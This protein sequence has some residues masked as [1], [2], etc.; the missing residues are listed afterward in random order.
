MT[1]EGNVIY[2]NPGNC[3]QSGKPLIPIR[4]VT[5]YSCL[6]FDSF[7]QDNPGVCPV[8][9]STLVPITAAL[10]FTCKGDW[11]IHELA[12][13]KCPD[14]TSRI[15]AYERRPHG[16]HNPRHGGQFFMADDNWHHVEGT[17]SKPNIFRVYFYNDMTH[18]LPVS[19]FS[20]RV[21]RDTQDNKD[22]KPIALKR[23]RTVDD[24][25]LEASMPATSLPASF[26]LWVK[27][28]PREKERVFNF[29]FASYSEETVILPKKLQA[30]APQTVSEGVTVMVD[31]V[32]YPSSVSN[33]PRPDE[34]LPTSRAGLLSE[35]AN[36]AQLV[37]RC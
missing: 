23:S 14:G 32:L 5:V 16:D 30:D 10:Y 28:N 21:K 34:P 15:R 2:D 11:N 18:P 26:T 36:R 6:K 20:A 29:T 4:I 33:A 25:M 24:N 35:L 7:V 9:K 27:F 1:G 31:S 17:W 13:G 22:K 37:K 12:P 8:D 19:D 3:P